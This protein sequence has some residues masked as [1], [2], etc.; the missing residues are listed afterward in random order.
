MT[1]KLIGTDD[2]TI[3]G[4]AG[5]NLFLLQKHTAEV[6]GACSE[7]RVK[8]SDSCNIRVAVYADDAGEPGAR[9]AKQ[10]TGQACVA[11]WNTIA[12]EASCNLVSGTV[13]WIATNC[14][15]EY[16][17]YDLTTGNY[18]YRTEA[19]A[20]PFTFP[21]PAGTGFTTGTTVIFFLAGWGTPVAAGRSFGLI[22]G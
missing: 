2:G 5:A 1:V 20:D 19:Y 10:D 8:C 18:R 12:L 6:T 13:Y 15:Q 16:I 4:A 14:D 11:G 17:G 3:D 7:V 21:A 22:I 9:L